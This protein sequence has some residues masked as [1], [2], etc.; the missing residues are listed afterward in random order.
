M[1]EKTNATKWYNIAKLYKLY[2][3]T[4]IFLLHY[5]KVV[6]KNQGFQSDKKYIQLKYI[7]EK[8][9]SVKIE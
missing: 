3:Y 6:K 1:S 9:Y 5:A 2:L 7:G 8:H 4:N